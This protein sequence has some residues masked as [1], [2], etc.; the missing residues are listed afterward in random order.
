[1]EVRES[2]RTFEVDVLCQMSPTDEEWNDDEGEDRC[3][4]DEKGPN[5]VS[6]DGPESRRPEQRDKSCVFSQ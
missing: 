5:D 2:F 4:D 6:K 3:D 1:M